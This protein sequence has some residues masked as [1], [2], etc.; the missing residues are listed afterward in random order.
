MI[1]AGVL[2]TLVV[3]ACSPVN[4]S[5]EDGVN[6]IQPSQEICEQIIADQRL[7]SAECKPVEGVARTKS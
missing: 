2:F 5:C 1:G 7:F 6:S 4:D 3:S